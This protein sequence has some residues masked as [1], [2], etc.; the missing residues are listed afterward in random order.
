MSITNNFGPFAEESIEREVVSQKPLNESWV[1]TRWRPLIAWQYFSVCLFD[2]I[3]GP[4]ITMIFFAQT[5][6]EYVQWSP[7]TIQGGGLYHLAMGAILGITSWSRM[8]EKLHR[9]ES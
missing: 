5:G 6:G 2:F 9:V 3:I 1:K 8:Q 4:V 7:L